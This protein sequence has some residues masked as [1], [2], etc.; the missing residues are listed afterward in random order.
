MTSTGPTHIIYD[1]DNK[2]INIT[3]P[4]SVSMFTYDGN[5]TRV[6]KIARSTTIYIGKLYECNSSTCVKYIYA[7][8]A[9]IAQEIAGTPSSIV[10]YHP[11]HLGST[12]AM[13]DVT[14]AKIEDVQ[15]F[16]F[17]ET[18]LGTSWGR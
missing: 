1:F 17:G 7:G 9:R 18:R 16:P 8:G 2:P 11:D 13:S 3:A 6:K 4:G 10:Y 15:Y 5:G 12:S 14:G